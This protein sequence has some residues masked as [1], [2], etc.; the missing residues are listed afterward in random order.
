M[1]HDGYESFVAD[2]GDQSRKGTPHVCCK[3]VV[4]IEKF[5]DKNTRN[6]MCQVVWIAYFKY[7]SILS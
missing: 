6:A 5:I 7:G 1:F 2:C 4:P 3:G